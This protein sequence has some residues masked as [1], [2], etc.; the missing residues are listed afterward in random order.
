MGRFLCE[1]HKLRNLDLEEKFLQDLEKDIDTYVSQVVS[2]KG[3]VLYK[4]K[5]PEQMMLFEAIRK[6]FADKQM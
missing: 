6:Y 2:T 1:A 5:E 3:E 4:E